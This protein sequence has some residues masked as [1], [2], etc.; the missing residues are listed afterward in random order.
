MECAEAF[1]SSVERRLCTIAQQP[2]YRFRDTSRA[3]AQ[4]YRDEQIE[5]AG[6]SEEQIQAV[7]AMSGGQLP[8]HYRCFLARMGHRQGALFRGSNLPAANEFDEL[9]RD[10]VELA[11]ET[12]PD[13]QLPAAAVVVLF[14]QGYVF[15]FLLADGGLDGPVFTYLEGRA[16]V[17]TGAP[18]FRAFVE[19]EL[20]GHEALHREQL[21]SGGHFLTVFDNGGTRTYSPARNSGIRPLDFADEFS[22]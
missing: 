15:N 9:R 18:S 5:F 22:D 4:R 17:E 2:A 11:R 12:L 8:H 20:A 6:F 1:F 16:D 13:F 10:C 21:D 14:H 19:A 7:E 3:A